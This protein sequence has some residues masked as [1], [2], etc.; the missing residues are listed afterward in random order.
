[1]IDFLAVCRLIIPVSYQPHPQFV[2]HAAS[3]LEAN[4]GSNSLLSRKTL[5]IPTVKL[6]KRDHPKCHQNVVFREAVYY[7]RYIWL[8]QIEWLPQGGLLS[9]A[10]LSSGWGWGLIASLTVSGAMISYVNPRFL[11]MSADLEISMLF[12]DFSLLTY[13]EMWDYHWNF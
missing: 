11:L 13:G 6:V 9:Q 10:G 5:G 7:Q 4:M 1:M 3:A 12:A 2:S 8:H